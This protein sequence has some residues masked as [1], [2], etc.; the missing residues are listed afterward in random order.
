MAKAREDGTHSAATS[1]TG[2]VGRYTARENRARSPGGVAEIE[3]VPSRRQ[4]SATPSGQRRRH[5]SKRQASAP[6]ETSMTT[7]VVDSGTT[8]SWSAGLRKSAPTAAPTK[9]QAAS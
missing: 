2:R 3:T 1:T 7:C 8:V 9:H 5:H 4:A 6:Q